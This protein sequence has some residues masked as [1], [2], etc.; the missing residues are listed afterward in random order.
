M[1]G[2]IGA[3][4]IVGQMLSGS[5]IEKHWV[6][7]GNP[8]RV[9]MWEPAFVYDGEGERIRNEVP[10]GNP[11]IWW[12]VVENREYDERYRLRVSPEVYRAFAPGDSISWEAEP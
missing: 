8:L 1:N 7:I 11:P 6:N 9:P 12:F 2:I 10:P 4:I 5:I 3:L